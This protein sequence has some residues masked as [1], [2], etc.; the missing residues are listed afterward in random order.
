MLKRIAEISGW[1]LLLVL[2]M[3]MY[4]RISVSRGQENNWDFRNYHYYNPYALL[5]DRLTFDVGPAFRQ[6]YNNPLLDV[7]L[8]LLVRHAR[9]QTVGFML[10]A[11]Q[12]LNLFLITLIGVQVLRRQKWWFAWPMALIMGWLGMRGVIMEYEM[13]ATYGDNLISLWILGGF[14][15]FLRGALQE[16]DGKLSAIPYIVAGLLLGMGTGLKLTAGIYV[17]GLCAA[18]LA[19]QAATRRRLF[20]AIIVGISGVMGFLATAGFWMLKMWRLYQN[21]FFP[22]FNNIFKSPYTY[23]EVFRDDRFFP[24]GWMEKLF[25]PFYFGFGHKEICDARVHGWWFAMLYLLC[26]L[27]LGRW[28][29]DW[30]IRRKGRGP[31][32]LQTATWTQPALYAP[33]LTFCIVTYVVWQ[34]MYSYYRYLVV[35]ELLCP[36]LVFVLLDRI[37]VHKRKAILLTILLL[38]IMLR[39]ADNFSVRRL[40]WT[41]NWFDLQ[42]PVL[43][44]PDKTIILLVDNRKP[45]A[46]LIPSF[47][48]GIRFIRTGGEGLWGPG[49]ETKMWQKISE[50]IE[51]HDGPIYSLGPTYLSK[52][53]GKMVNRKIRYLNLEVIPNQV[54]NV[55]SKMNC[56]DLWQ[57]R[58]C[59]EE[60]K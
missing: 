43:E 17:V 34:V 29:W 2:S 10:G 36:V 13:G 22:Y 12:G 47:P 55:Y 33:M 60:T 30:W 24:A 5:H 1:G 16:S 40:P 37:L 28:L 20:V 59:P 18:A 25:Y 6:T 39:W 51:Q 52:Y 49:D 4:G 21:P 32:N 11:V 15:F 35:L 14:Y 48:P 8:Y 57:L 54:Q 44:Q 53:G 26:V 50:I 27:A 19:V 3:L 31:G 58:K 42:L 46:F 56:D 9:P 41:D 23:L 38:S 45:L 7:P